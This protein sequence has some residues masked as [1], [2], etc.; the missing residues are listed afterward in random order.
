MDDFEIVKKAFVEAELQHVEAK[1]QFVSVAL[2]NWAE[3]IHGTTLE[4]AGKNVRFRHEVE[5][6]EMVARAAMLF[7]AIMHSPTTPKDIYGVGNA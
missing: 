2:E 7:G 6:I 3:V 4:E 1:N 5:F